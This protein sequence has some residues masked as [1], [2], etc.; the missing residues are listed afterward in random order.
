MRRAGDDHSPKLG[1]DAPIAYEISEANGDQM[2]NASSFYFSQ[3]AG[4]GQRPSF[5]QINLKVKPRTSASISELSALHSSSDEGKIILLGIHRRYGRVKI[6]QNVFMLNLRLRGVFLLLLLLFNA[7]S[8]LV[9]LLLNE[10]RESYIDHRLTDRCL[11]PTRKVS[12]I[13]RWMS[14]VS[15]QCSLSNIVFSTNEKG[16]RW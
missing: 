14:M 9:H 11:S 7:L 4:C 8:S 15:D 13:N 1:G 16:L 12:M 10:E 2:Q 6:R 5:G 3:S